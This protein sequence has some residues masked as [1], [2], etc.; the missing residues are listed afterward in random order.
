MS[1][2]SFSFAFFF[3]IFAALYYFCHRLNNN[4]LLF[5][6]ILLLAASI[7]F[8]AFADLK[9]LPFLLYAIAVCFLASICIGRGY[10]SRLLLIVADFHIFQGEL[11]GP[12]DDLVPGPSGIRRGVVD[13]CEH[14]LRQPDG[15]DRGLT[16]IF[17][18]PDNKLPV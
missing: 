6:R 3:A 4:S 7:I 2:I 8:Y 17:V 14:F 13:R 10:K 16:A 1:F 12:D 11:Q 5:Q 9:F 15:D 18:R